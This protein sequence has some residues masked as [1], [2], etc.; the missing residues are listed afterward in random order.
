MSPGVRDFGF[1]V[2]WNGLIA[3]RM[4]LAIWFSQ[5]WAIDTLVTTDFHSF[6]N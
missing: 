2:T 3:D 1:E 6:D 4:R 5:P